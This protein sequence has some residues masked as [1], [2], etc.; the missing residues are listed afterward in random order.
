MIMVGLRLTKGGGRIGALCLLWVS[1]EQPGLDPPNIPHEN[2]DF[3]RVWGW[4]TWALSERQPIVISRWFTVQPL[5][6]SQVFLCP[7][8]DYYRPKPDD[9]VRLNKYNI[10]WLPFWGALLQLS[11]TWD[12]E[13]PLIFARCYMMGYLM[14]AK[15]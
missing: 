10:W 12:E 11:M 15:W 13:T 3:A 5:T 9:L 4:Q 7:N 6:V 2:F 1:E 8:L 14:M